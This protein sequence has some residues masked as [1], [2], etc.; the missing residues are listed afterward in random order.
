MRPV[1]PGSPCA[2]SPGE[3]GLFLRRRQPEAQV[4][5]RRTALLGR[6]LDAAGVGVIG[7]LQPPDV[8]VL[9]ELHLLR[10]TT[11]KECHAPAVAVA[12][13]NSGSGSWVFSIGAS[14]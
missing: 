7:G 2:N 10:L 11:N 8:L 9:V 6:D 1:P 13:G 3:A 14:R 5:V 4:A 12:G